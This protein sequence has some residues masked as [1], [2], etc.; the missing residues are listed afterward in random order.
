M[1][2]NGRNALET[3]LHSPAVEIGCLVLTD[4]AIGPAFTFNALGQ[5]C[6]GESEKEHIF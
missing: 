1:L 5:G 3:E 4:C 2:E 6:T